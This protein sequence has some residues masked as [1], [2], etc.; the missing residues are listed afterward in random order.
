MAEA[1]KNKE[2]LVTIKIPRNSK[3]NSDVFVSVNEKTWLIKRGVAVEVPLCVAEQI[4]HQE[5]MEEEIYQFE[6]SLQK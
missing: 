2:E 3:D 1:K 6:E 5:R 4:Q